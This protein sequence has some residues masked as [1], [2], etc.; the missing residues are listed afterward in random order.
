MTFGSPPTPTASDISNGERQTIRNGRATVPDLHSRLTKSNQRDKSHALGLPKA[1]KNAKQMKTDKSKIPKINAP[2]SELTKTYNHIPIRN[3]EEWVN[4]PT[5]VRRK[6]VEKRNGYVTRPMNSFMLY[7]SAYAERTKMWCLQNNHQIVSSVSGESWPMEPPE[8]REQYNEYARIERDNH[9]KAH[10]GYKFSPSKAQGNGRKRKETPE[11]SADEEPSDLDDPDFEW[12][13]SA[14]RRSKARS[15]KRQGR[16]AGYPV[17]STPQ[18]HVHGN[19]VQQENAYNRSSYQATNPGKP[20]PAVMGEQNM[21]GQYYQTTVHPSYRPNVE[22]VRIRKMEAP[23]KGF[24]N[25]PPLLGLPGT[26]HHELLDERS[27]DSG[28]SMFDQNQVDPTLLTFD[29]VYAAESN[30]VF[31]EQQFREYNNDA[32]LDATSQSYRQYDGHVYNSESIPWQY[33]DVAHASGGNDFDN[34]IEENND[35]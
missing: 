32:L 27:L 25:A 29:G 18:S 3:M 35:R 31:T 4:R 17:N 5:E 23:S 11:I 14:E 30:G 33:G 2:L 6:E 13:P 21:F 8:V 34:W 12:R 10:P 15:G 16:E 19:L 28:P 22:D 24:D 26:H 9:Q 20:P 7:R 1:K